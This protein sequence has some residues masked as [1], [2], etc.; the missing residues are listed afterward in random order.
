M[1][2]FLVLG[3]SGAVLIASFI[4]SDRSERLRLLGLLLFVAGT[5]VLALAI[6]SGR[7]AKRGM[8][9]R[10][11]LLGVPMFCLAYFAWEIYGPPALR[12][13]ARTGF[14]LIAIVLAP[15]N[16]RAGIE[17]RNWFDRGFREVEQDLRA[18]VPS[19][20]LAARHHAFLHE[21]EAVLA[22][23]IRMLHEARFGPFAR[24]RDDAPG[25]AAE[26]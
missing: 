10:Y 21:D 4:R 5:V 3:G 2:A 20:V 11:A 16:L 13:L 22:R 23:K 25:S 8:S 18:E 24:I 15:F 1:V 26:R 14:L 12:K 19:A 6:G 7:A 9:T 17:R